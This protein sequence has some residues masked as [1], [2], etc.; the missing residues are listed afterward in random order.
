MEP[1]LQADGTALSGGASRLEIL[2]L[3]ATVRRPVGPNS[4]YVHALLTHLERA[5]LAWTPRFLGIDA[6]G[7][8]VLS[9]IEGE[10]A[11]GVDAWSESRL[12]ALVALI[13]QMHD[14]TAGSALAGAAEVVCHHD[15]APWNTVLREGVPVA[16]IDFNDAAPGRCV[17]DLGYFFWVF[18][19]L[20]TGLLAAE[21]ARRMA[22]LCARY[23]PLDRKSLV[24]AILRQQRR[25]L[26]M[27]IRRARESTA[28]EDRAWETERAR[29]I[30]REMHWVREWRA[31][32]ERA[33][34]EIPA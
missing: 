1:P 14:A 12:D 10:V 17:D 31:V 24:P 33:L 7:R 11:H 4:G 15:L 5:G 21:Q 8:E 25:V 6:A 16:F 29:Q 22:R 28:S 23:G 18:L 27:R 32:L 30:R 34:A 9:F 20:G 26:A 2:R 3:G 19:G 13:R